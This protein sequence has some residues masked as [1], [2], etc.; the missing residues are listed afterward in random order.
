MELEAEIAQLK[1]LNEE[2]QKKQV[3]LA[4]SLSQLRISRFSYFLEVVFTDQMF[5]AG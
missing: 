4:S 3:C 5:H 2:L 1:E